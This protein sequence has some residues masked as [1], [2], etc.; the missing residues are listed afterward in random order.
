MAFV[1]S[2]P[3]K[4]LSTILLE[5]YLKRSLPTDSAEEPEK[6]G[7]KM[8]DSFAMLLKTNGEKMSLFLS[9]A[10]LMKVNDLYAVSRDVDDT[11]GGYESRG[12]GLSTGSW[13]LGILGW[14]GDGGAAQ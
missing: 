6:G 11:I 12:G 2:A 9:L 14:M 1:P 5:L 3:P 4:S 8:K 10:M 13:R 7:Q